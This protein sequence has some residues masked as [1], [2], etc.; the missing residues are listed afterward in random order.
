VLDALARLAEVDGRASQARR[1]A[2]QAGAAWQERARLLP[3]TYAAHHAEHLLLHGDPRRA[4]ALARADHGRRPYPGTIVHYAYALW[5]SGEPARALAVVRRGD[6]RGFL[7]AEMKLVE[8]I[9]LASLGRA[10]EAGTVLAE[11]RRLNPNIDS[12]RQQFVAF[13][14]D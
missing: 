13:G 14:R 2:A 4:V 3:M 1:W 9:S 5:R 8:A 6:A 7:T 11:A 12:Q 10:A